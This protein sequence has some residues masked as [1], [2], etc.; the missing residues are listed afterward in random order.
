MREREKGKGKRRLETVF[1]FPLSVFLL[2]LFSEKQNRK[3]ENRCWSRK[4]KIEKRK[5]FS[6][7]RFFF[8][9]FITKGKTQNGKQKRKTENGQR[10]TFTLSVFLFRFRL[11]GKR[12]PVQKQKGQSGRRFPFFFFPFFTKRI[13]KMEKDFLFRFSLHL[14]S[15]S[16]KWK[17]Q[18]WKWK[19]KPKRGKRAS[20]FRIA[21]F[22]SRKQKK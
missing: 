17:T 20:M 19:P 9:P 1:R 5:T 10:K 22:I 14:F 3:T 2:F 11:N 4:E 8:F 21:F 18:N 15:F 16:W 13:T 6:T 7:F 12:F